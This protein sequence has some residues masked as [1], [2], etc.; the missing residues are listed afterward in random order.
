MKL[1]KLLSATL[2]I[3]GLLNSKNSSAQTWNLIGNTNLTATSKLGGS[4]ATVG[5]NFPL[6]LFTYNAERI[7]INANVAGKVG[8]VGIGT[9]AP[10][11]MLHV[12][13]VITATGGTSTAWNTAVTRLPAGTTNKVPRWNGTAYIAGSIFDNGTNIGIGTASPT[14]PLSFPN[15]LGNRISFY[16]SGPNNDFG[17]GINT[18][19]MQLFTAG[20]DK[21]AFGWGNSN[22]F[23]ENLSVS[24]G[25]GQLKYSNSLGNKISFYNSGP[26]ND[27][28]I[29][30]NTG[31]MQFF[32]A[33]QDKIAFGWGNSNNFTET[34]TFLTGSGQ[35]GLGTSTPAYKLD[36]CGTIR[37][38]EVRVATGWCDYVF[39]DDYK[40]PA[41][42]E[43]EAFIKT[44]KHLPEVTPG[45][46]IESEGLEIGK[47]SA[48]MIKKIEEL[49]LYVIDLQKQVNELKKN[50]K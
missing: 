50:D 10:A 5:Q 46:V 38:K 16:N 15:T 13:G 35:L 18:G 37:A 22:S 34:M 27:Y 24:T 41:L 8:Y 33:G 14:S 17:I 49:T 48:Q 47:T 7:H 25:T 11:T 4:S 2:L 9:A 30:I 32:T 20:Q 40:L 6:R 12:N 23:N 43:V 36:V 45:A 44:N 29:G 21:I 39:A 42:S 28:G 3:A 31:V 26:N 19:V 1:K